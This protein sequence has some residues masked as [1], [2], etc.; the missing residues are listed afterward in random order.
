MAYIYTYIYIFLI[1]TVFSC[2]LCLK[3]WVHLHWYYGPFSAL[4][5]VFLHVS[6]QKLFSTLIIMQKCFFSSNQHIRMISEGSC[7]S[8]DWS[9][10]AEN[11]ALVYW[12]KLHFNIFSHRKLNI[13]QYYCFTVLFIIEMQPWWAKEYS[14][15][16]I[17]KSYPLK[18]VEC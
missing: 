6:V 13:S 14:F 18:T 8:E 5:S 10:D 4:N 15:K 12:N 1:W 2:V 16:H 9:N 17:K 3:C 11:T 7:D